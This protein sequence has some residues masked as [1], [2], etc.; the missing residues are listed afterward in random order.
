MRSGH[1]LPSLNA[2]AGPG[3]N[4]LRSSLNPELQFTGTFA[5]PIQGLD[6]GFLDLVS[7]EEA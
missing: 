5:P 6:D 2:D 1:Q 3:A 7:L 4:Q